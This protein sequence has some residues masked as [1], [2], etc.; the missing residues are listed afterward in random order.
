MEQSLI[1]G[2]HRPSQFRKATKSVAERN[3]QAPVVHALLVC[4]D[5]GGTIPPMVALV[6]AF[7][8]R[9]DEVTVLSQPSVRSR[10]EAAGGRFRAFSALGDYDHGRSFEDQLDLIGAAIVGREVGDDLLAVEAD[11][12]VVDANLAG[13][14][15]AAE[16]LSVP[17]AVLLHSM[18]A[19]FTDV[20]FAELWPHLAAA[21]NETRNSYG[22]DGV[23]GWPEVFAAHDRLVSVVPPALDAPSSVPAP[24][25]LRHAGFLVPRPAPS[26]DDAVTYPT[27]DDPTVLVSL[28]TTS[29]GQAAQL[30]HAVDVLST[31][32][33]RAVVTTAGQGGGLSSTDNVVVVDYV[34][35]A[36]LLPSTDVVVCH[37]GLGTVAAALD[38]GVPLVCLPI[39]RDQPLNAAR[40]A[41]VGAGGTVDGDLRASVERVLGDESMREAAGAIGEAG[42]AAGGA[43]GVV[44]ELEELA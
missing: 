15:A 17:T 10:A 28:G 2:H 34:P 13:A 22:L 27:G 18:W 35:H 37:A 38:T 5:A 9:G 40:V 30:A 29:Q 14:L 7:V 25:S 6:E 4:H 41:A 32:A 42:R 23:D 3:W 44:R 33:V 19:T 20:W 36:A 31:M 12:V 11:V 1:A 21:V 39:D 8:A 24:P 16:T 26:I 43:D